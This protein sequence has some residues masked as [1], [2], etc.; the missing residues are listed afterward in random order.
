MTYLLGDY[1][2][3]VLRLSPC[4]RN[5]HFRFVGQRQRAWMPRKIFERVTEAA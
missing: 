2:I 5:V 3:R 4:R 1:Y